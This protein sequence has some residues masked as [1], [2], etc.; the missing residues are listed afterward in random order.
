MY[1]EMNKY[2]NHEE[3]F[4][5]IGVG[6]VFPAKVVRLL[7]KKYKNLIGIAHCHGPEPEVLAESYKGVGW[8]AQKI[9]K[10]NLQKMDGIWS[11]GKDTQ[12]TLRKKGF[13]SLIIKNGVDFE[14]LNIQEPYNYGDIGLNKEIV[15]ATIGSVSK[16]KGYYEIIEAVSI[17]KEKYGVSIHFVGIGKVDERTKKIFETYAKQFQVQNQI[18]L[19]GEHRNVVEYAKGADIMI[20]ASGG[21][22]YG[23][24]M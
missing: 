19:I 3:K 15:V 8:I 12:A 7:K 2:L 23:I 16:V 5:V 22:G 14:V 21:G 10:K 13:D 6:T 1:R 24:S 20:C 18:H 4:Y 11:N 9:Q 17:L